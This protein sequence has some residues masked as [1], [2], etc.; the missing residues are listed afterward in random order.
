MADPRSF[1]RRRGRRRH[2]AR[3][4]VQAALCPT[5]AST[6]SRAG[7]GPG[8]CASTASARRRAT[9]SRPARRSAFPPAEATPARDGPPAAQAR[10]A[11]RRGRRAGPR[12][13]HPRGPRTPSCSTS[14]RA[15]R[16]R[17]GPRRT[18]ISTGCSTGWP[19]MRA[20]GPSSSTGS[21]RTRRAPAGRPDRA[22]GGP[23]R[24][25]LLRP[26]RAQGLLGA[27]R[28]RAVARRGPDRR[29]RS[30]SSPGT[31]G[32]KM[33]VDEENGLPAR[34]RCRV[35]DRAGN[36][37]AW[38]ELQPLTGRTH[39][40]RAHMAA[41]GH[42]IVGDAKYGG[43]EA[44]LTGG[45]SRKLHLHARRIRIDAPERRQIDV[46]AELPPHI[47]REP[48]DA[49]LRADGRRNMPPMRRSRPAQTP[50]AKQ[51]Q[52]AAAAKTR[53]RE[54]TRRAPLARRSPA[55]KRRAQVNRL[56]I[57]DCDGTLVDS[58]GNIH[59][60]ARRQLRPSTA[61]PVPPPEA[62]PQGDRPQPGRSDGRAGARRRSRSARRAGRELQAATSSRSRRRA[63]RGAA[64]STAFPNCSTRWR[65][66]AGC[67]RSR[68][69]SRTAGSRICLDC[70]GI[71]ARFVSLQT[72]DRHPSKPHPSMA[73]QAMADA[74]AA[75]ETTVV[76]GDTASTWAWRSR[77]ARPAIGAGWG[78]HEPH[79][80]LDGGRDRR[81]PSSRSTCSSFV[82]DD[83]GASLW[84]TKTLWKRRFLLFMLVA[85]DRA[86][87]L[88]ARR[89]PSPTPIC[90]RG[91]AGRRSAR[92]SPSSARS[93]RCSRRECS[94]SCGSSRTATQ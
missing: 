88:R 16:R 15:W 89:L 37:A 8:S 56:A 57:F 87:D 71:R 9:G 18:S 90:L 34:T 46:T 12:D 53:R 64:C 76:I 49:R 30:P 54:R 5:S 36:R 39:Q 48:G 2:P 93:M 32:E 51:R 33:H 11:D 47:R 77:P 72:A 74:G 26:D 27:G 55:R 63:G 20:T 19:T 73:L 69:A 43:P 25:G 91:A 59:R 41:I 83:D 38:V 86:G 75:P 62:T 28:R 50:E 22:R 1:H 78:Y 6:S 40:L 66:T 13:G 45:I 79:E 81:S 67:S 58:G 35:I 42:P 68:P 23:F 31:G 85:A 92:S 65:P 14:R 44:F 4:L 7:R 52:A 3:P 70:H 61:L 10:A 84:L 80:M 24:Q 82:P 29:C 17:A 94:R 21:T 60:R